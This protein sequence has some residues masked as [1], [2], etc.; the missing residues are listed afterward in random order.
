VKTAKGR[1]AY[2]L[3]ARAGRSDVLRLFES[4]GAD[5]TLDETDT[6]LAACSSGDAKAARAMVNANP[7]L[8]DEFTEEDRRD[9]LLAA[10]S[11]CTEGVQVMLD[12]GFDIDIQGDWGGSAV[13]HAAWHGQSETVGLLVARG[14]NLELENQ[15]GGTALDTAV[16]A[17]DHSGIKNVDYV[18]VIERLLDGGADVNAVRPFPSGN[19]R[20]D[21]L[22]RKYGRSG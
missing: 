1:T 10:A 5:T 6:F 12:A 21:M 8:M 15:Y 2:A 3:A 13:H 4:H 7:R 9:I 11:G 20:V 14:A 22:L 17:V 18:P 16:W 19:E